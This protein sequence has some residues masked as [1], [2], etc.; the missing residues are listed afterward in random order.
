MFGV[1]QPVLQAVSR[2]GAVLSAPSAVAIPSSHQIPTTAS[3][4]VLKSQLPLISPQFFKPLP[5]SAAVPQP[6]PTLL[7]IQ[8]LP[9]NIINPTPLQVPAT[10]PSLRHSPAPEAVVPTKNHFQATSSVNRNN[11]PTGSQSQPIPTIRVEIQSF[12]QLPIQ[13]LPPTSILPHPSANI[14]ITATPSMETPMRS[15]RPLMPEHQGISPLNPPWPQNAHAHV[16]G[17]HASASNPSTSSNNRLNGSLDQS[18]NYRV[19]ANQNNAGSFPAGPG[20]LRSLYGPSVER[21]DFL[22]EPDFEQW[23]PENSPL[24]AGDFHP[25]RNY[26]EPR[27]DFGRRYRSEWPRQRNHGRRDH[28]SGNRRWW[29]RDRRRH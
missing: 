28:R 7:S 11:L 26:N 16:I 8:N 19:P 2:G 9:S 1:P 5:V 14:S 6:H 10:I 12:G 20:Q 18:F 27:W 4:S 21:N 25:D 24:R 22:D 29:D 17:K 13:K 23:S 3:S 15:Q